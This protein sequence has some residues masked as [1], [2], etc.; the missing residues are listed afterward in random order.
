[1]NDPAPQS[2]LTQLAAVIDD[3][4]QNP[5]PDS[6]TSQLLANLERAAQKVG[7]EGVEVVVAT[8][9]QSR[10]QLIAESADLLYHL[11]VVLAA[12]DVSL[13][14]VEDELVKRHQ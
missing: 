13:A 1:M 6:Y 10:E 9:S 8:L 11:L 3:R 2:F 14:E 4:K 7:E 12:R 5:Q